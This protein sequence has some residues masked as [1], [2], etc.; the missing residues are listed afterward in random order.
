MS[1]GGGRFGRRGWTAAPAAPPALPG[2]VATQAPLTTATESVATESVATAGKRLGELLLQRGLLDQARLDEVLLQQHASDKPLGALLLELGLLDE[3]QLAEAMS[4]QSG[5]PLVDLGRLEPKPEIVG[6]LTEAMARQAPAIALR[7]VGD[8]VEVAVADPFDE[9]LAGQIRAAVNKPVKLFLAPASDIRRTIDTSYRALS[10]ME[11]HVAAFESAAALRRVEGPDQTVLAGEAPVVQAVNLMVTQALRDRASDIHIEPQGDRLRVR[12]RIDGALHDALALPSNMAA[13]IVSRV[14]VIA[15]MD[16]V[17]RRRAHDGQF[18]TEIDG[19][20]VDVRVATAPTIWGEKAVLRLLDRG[21]LLFRLDELGMSPT[22][23]ELY[24]R[25]IASPIGMV[26]SAGPTGSGKTT[27]LYATLSEINSIERNITTIEDPVEYVF[28][29]INQI[30]INPQAGIT[31]AGGLRAIL[32]QD[33]D[34]IL[35]GEVRDA[36]TAQIAVQSALTGHLVLSSLH[37]VDAASALH[38]LLEMGIESYLVASSVIGVVSQRLL[39]RICDNCR[40]PY[41]PSVDELALYEKYGGPPKTEFTHGEGCNFCSQT[42]YQSRVGV[43]EL[44]PV[45]DSVKEILVRKG[46]QRELRDVAVAEGMRTIADEAARLVAND[47]TLISEIS[48]AVYSL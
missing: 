38:R 1:P 19:R 45:T 21:R 46:A 4:I 6:L 33:P 11:R 37:A 5:L 15:D 8:A 25:L 30:Q 9:A 36:E 42:G 28:G 27:T 26:I 31:F 24:S 22:T 12:Y 14:K 47:V 13:A 44:M 35:V 2:S 43:F 29:S 32:R 20:P 16:I 7:L 18:A 10:G 48:R 40:A 17:D 34:V 3:R 39:R 23:H 41:E